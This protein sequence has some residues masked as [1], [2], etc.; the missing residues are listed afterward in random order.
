MILKLLAD[1]GAIPFTQTLALVPKLKDDSHEQVVLAAIGLATL[2][3]QLIPSGL[4]NEYSRFVDQS[5]GDRARRL[6]WT[7][8]AGESEN[9]QL[10]RTKLVPFVAIVGRDE[11]LTRE[12]K[13]LAP[14]WLRRHDI[15][16]PDVAE[17][18][19]DAAAR[20]GD[21]TLFDEILKA[22]KAEPDPSIRPLLV[23]TLGAFR[24]KAL[25]ERAFRLAFDGTFDIRESFR[26]MMMPLADPA[27]ADLPYEYIKAH[28]D[29]IVPKFPTG[30]GI[31]YAAM[32][33]SFA[34]ASAC[35]ESATERRKDVLWTTYAESARRST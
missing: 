28:Y 25:L 16:S 23:R 2:R 15:V 1:T 30:I 31:D 14:E 10:L 22:A 33:P 29:E 4:R 17:G 24:D 11:E 8:E 20:D 27:L 3:N 7:P 13:R 34:T 12:A 21:A 26:I 19:L 32:F 18:M 5:F 35:S 9:V 6:G